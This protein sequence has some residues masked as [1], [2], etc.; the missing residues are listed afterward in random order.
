MHRKEKNKKHEVRRLLCIICNALVERRDG[1]VPVQ[2]Y[3][4][5][6]CIDSWYRSQQSQ[7]K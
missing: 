4:R 3:V 2:L 5:R 6:K 1:S 7:Q